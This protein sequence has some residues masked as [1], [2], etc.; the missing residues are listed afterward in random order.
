MKK[1]RNNQVDSI[2]GRENSK[3]KGSE[4]GTRGG[5]GTEEGRR[6]GQAGKEQGQEII[7]V[8]ETPE[9]LAEE[10]RTDFKLEA[11]TVR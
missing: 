10:C 7:H 3:C 6:R 9:G 1:L 4:A 11:V 2:L 5:G 8:E